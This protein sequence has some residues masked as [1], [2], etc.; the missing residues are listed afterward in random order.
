MRQGRRRIRFRVKTLYD[1]EKLIKQARRCSP[2]VVR[3]HETLFQWEV[4]DESGGP[5]I[6]RF[7]EIDDAAAFVCMKDGLLIM[8]KSMRAAKNLA[9]HHR[10]IDLF[11]E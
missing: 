9:M 1:C 8:R 11:K 5:P 3:T 4:Y 2:D 7:R 6:A 10:Q